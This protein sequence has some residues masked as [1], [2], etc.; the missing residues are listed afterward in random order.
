MQFGLRRFVTVAALCSLVLTF[1]KQSALGDTGELLGKRNL[2]GILHLG[3]FG[4]QSK[5]ECTVFF[6]LDGPAAK[7]VY[8]EI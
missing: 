6:E 4:C 1:N 2:Q 5:G 8:H 3:E 7:T